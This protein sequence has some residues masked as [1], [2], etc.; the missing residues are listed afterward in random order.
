VLEHDDRKWKP[1]FVKNRFPLDRMMFYAIFT[2]VF[3]DTQRM[4]GFSSQWLALREEADILARS[5]EVLEQLVQQLRSRF[6][7]SHILRIL[8]L[9]CGTGSQFRALSPHLP[10]VQDWVLVDQDAGLLEEARRLCSVARIR[11]A[12][13]SD[14]LERLIEEEKPDFITASAL[15][16]LAGEAFLEHLAVCVAARHGVFYTVLTYDGREEWFPRHPLDTSVL[17]AFHEHQRRDKGLGRACGP[18]ATCVLA[19]AFRRQGY[20]VHIGTSDWPLDATKSHT[21]M[22]AL[23]RGIVEA[24]SETGRLLPADLALWEQ[25]RRNSTRAMIGHKDLLA[26]REEGF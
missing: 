10:F 2:N 22:Q 18:Q 14:S 13:L 8:D 4:S 12:N 15:F 26:W 19:E 7:P 20:K 6:P 5:R 24:A 3:S 9:G 23:I 11:Q 21:L 16:D 17:H 1:V 25:T